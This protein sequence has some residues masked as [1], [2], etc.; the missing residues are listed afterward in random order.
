MAAVNTE[1]GDLPNPYYVNPEVFFKWVANPTLKEVSIQPR[2]DHEECYRA[3]AAVEKY[4]GLN[5]EELLRRRWQT[6]ETIEMFKNVFM[7][8]DEQTRPFAREGLL[9]AGSPDADFAGMARY[10]IRDEWKLKLF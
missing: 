6:Y 8:G 3:H 5:R 9:N 2:F 10:F 7:V 1:R 4:Y